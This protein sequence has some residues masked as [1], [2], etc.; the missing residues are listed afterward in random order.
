MAQERRYAMIETIK[1]YG[2]GG[3]VMAPISEGRY[4]KGRWQNIRITASNKTLPAKINDALLHMVIPTVFDAEQLEEGELTI[5]KLSRAAYV[6]DVT[7]L[8][9]NEGKKEEARELIL[10]A[11]EHYGE[12]RYRVIAFENGTYELVE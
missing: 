7:E 9:I 3:G 4:I 11:L 8:L 10:S 1:F 5:P 2:P 6:E 12:E